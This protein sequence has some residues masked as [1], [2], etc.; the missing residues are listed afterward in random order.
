[1]GS[2]GTQ[3]TRPVVE[4]RASWW[5]CT[6]TAFLNPTWARWGPG[7]PGRDHWS[8]HAAAA[9][10]PLAMAQFPSVRWPFPS[11]ETLPRAPGSPPS[12][13]SPSPTSFMLDLFAWGPPGHGRPNAWPP[14]SPRTVTSHSDPKSVHPV[15]CPFRISPNLA[16]ITNPLA[17]LLAPVCPTRWPDWAPGP[18]VG[19]CT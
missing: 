18:S 7:R 8:R 9:L 2:P 1:M 14:A 12:G 3:T 10:R 17:C 15:S 11:P 6:M 5:S 13:H 16:L 4:G 19:L